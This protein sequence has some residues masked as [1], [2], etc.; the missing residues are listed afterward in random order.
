VEI[1]LDTNVLLAAIAKNNKWRPIYDAF[2]GEKYI[3]L[4]TTE[5]Y[6]EYIEKLQEKTS[7]EVAYNIG[8]VLETKNNILIVTVSFK[9][10]LIK[11]D[12]DD[13]KFA[14]CAIAGNADYLVTNDS[15]YRILKQLA[16]PKLN[17]VTAEEFLIILQKNEKR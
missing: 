12:A 17:I 4:I 13:N 3:L 14:D 8:R 1:A 2:I 10:G 9:W 7:I 6:L 5:I 11:S 15:D 16:F